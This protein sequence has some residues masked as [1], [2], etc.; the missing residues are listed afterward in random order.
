MSGTR[1]RILQRSLFV[2]GFFATS[3]APAG[4]ESVKTLDNPGGGQAVYGPLTGDTSLRAGMGDV[5][6]GVH[7]HFGDRPKIGRLFQTKS[8]D[9]VACFFTLTAKNYG[10]KRIAGL[11]I[12]TMPAGARPAGAVLYDDADRFARRLDRS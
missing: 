6:H 1:F 4:A 5:L 10:G 11:A 3:L 12:V 8:G 7:H 2:L 9:S